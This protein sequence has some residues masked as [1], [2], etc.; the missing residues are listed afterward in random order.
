M[1]YTAESVKAGLRVRD[2]R[3]VFYLGAEDRLTPAARDWLRQENVAILPQSDAV[4]QTYTTPS[5]GTLTEK[6]E[7]MTHLAGNVLV[8]KGHPRIAF[9]GMID[10]L[11]A[12]LLLCQC[13]ARRENHGELVRNLQEILDFVRSLIRADVL[14]EPVGEVRL[15]G[16]DADTLR[17]HS[18]Y[19]AK[20]YQQPHFMPA[21]T[22]GETILRL[23]LVRTVVRQT[24]LACFRAFRNTDGAVTRGDIL[25]ALNRLSSL[26][27]I[28]MIRLKA[29]K[30]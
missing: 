10:T 16:M 23:N 18:H 5:G 4:P 24:E 25:L 28:L 20:Y 13:A 15:C 19:P 22:D 7:D 2:G 14:N 27:W 8:S 1:L 11:E 26:C 3:R 21:D 17:E 9:R 6:P 30:Q 12:Q 29:E